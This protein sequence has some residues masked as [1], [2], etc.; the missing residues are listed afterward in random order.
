MTAP[1]LAGQAR[2]EE[3]VIV[4]EPFR[5]ALPNSWFEPALAVLAK[6]G[7]PVTF[8][9]LDTGK[10]VNDQPTITVMAHARGLARA[11]F[12]AFIPG[13]YRVVAA[14]PENDGQAEFGIQCVTSEFRADLES[15]AYARRYLAREREAK[16]RRKKAEAEVAERVRRK[17]QGK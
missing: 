17:R 4:G 13:D 14:S 7:R 9:A 5:L 11:P 3:L 6:P 10:F 1:K 8:V 2:F 12:F 16:E 15:G